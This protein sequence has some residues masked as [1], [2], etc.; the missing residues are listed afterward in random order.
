MSEEV[1][2]LLLTQ[3]NKTVETSMLLVQR[4][5]CNKIDVAV[6]GM[7]QKF[8]KK[9]ETF[10]ERLDTLCNNCKITKIVEGNPELGQKGMRQK[11]DEHLAFHKR[12]KKIGQVILGILTAALGAISLEDVRKLFNR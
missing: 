1:T 12:I 3:I 4:E 8:D 7:T 5:A 11:L 10:D 9:L 6:M 2:K